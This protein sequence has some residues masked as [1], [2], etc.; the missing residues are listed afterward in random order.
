MRQYIE[1]TGHGDLSCEFKRLMLKTIKI[2]VTFNMQFI[3]LDR[4][5]FNDD[6]SGETNIIR[7]LNWFGVDLQL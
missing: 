3:I 7:E 5:N 2:S 6:H 1:I 4:K